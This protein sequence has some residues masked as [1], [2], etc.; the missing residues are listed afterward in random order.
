MKS[1]LIIAGAGLAIVAFASAFANANRGHEIADAAEKADNGWGSF[2]N[3]LVMTLTNKNGQKT[4]RKMHGYT[5]EVKGDGDK[6]MIVFDTPKDVKG[7]SSMTFTHKKGDDEQWLY[8]PAVKRVKRIS[9]SNKS[10]PFMG[11]EFAFEDLS[12]QELEK[13]TYKYIKEEK[14]DTIMCYR[15]ERYPVSKTSGYKKNVVWF[16]KKN[17]RVE[18]IRFYDRKGSKLKTL[19]F[20][21]YKKYL[22]K[23][24]RANI[25]KMVNHQNSKKTYLKFTN[26][27]F[28]IDLTDEDFTQNALKRAK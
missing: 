4:V 8:L 17:Y 16:N 15:V 12:S 20:K 18:R 25:M 13:F 19:Y 1:K 27:K 23:Y 2:S 21:K 3:A 14:I 7:T 28:G 5:L 26:Y 24:W 6:S 9:S 10:G 11:S 22:G